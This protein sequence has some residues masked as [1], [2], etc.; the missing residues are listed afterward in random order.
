MD[1]NKKRIFDKEKNEYTF[2]T[3]KSL[4]KSIY[5]ASNQFKN[6]KFELIITDSNS[7]KEDIDKI[8]KILSHSN[9]RNKFISINSDDFKN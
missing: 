4:I 6:I 9:I 3:L 8:Q 7:P 2:R 1:Q 5:A